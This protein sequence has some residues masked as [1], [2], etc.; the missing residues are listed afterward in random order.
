M[1]QRFQK[2]FKQH[3]SSQSFSLQKTMV[4]IIFFGGSLALAPFFWPAAIPTILLI[5]L[6]L[7]YF[8]L[9]LM[10]LIHYLVHLP[11]GFLIGEKTVSKHEFR[12]LFNIPMEII[13]M[14]FMDQKSPD[15]KQSNPLQNNGSEENYV[16]ETD[17]TESYVDETDPTESYVDETDLQEDPTAISYEDDLIDGTN[18]STEGNDDQHH[19]QSPSHASDNTARNWSYQYVDRPHTEAISE[20][21]VEESD[22]MNANLMNDPAEKLEQTQDYTIPPVPNQEEEQ[23]ENHDPQQLGEAYLENGVLSEQSITEQI[24]SDLATEPQKTNKE[25]NNLDVK[26]ESESTKSNTKKTNNKKTNTKKTNTKKTNTKKTK[27][28]ENEK[29]KKHNPNMRYNEEGYTEILTG[30]NKWELEHVMIAESIIDRKLKA[31]EVIHHI[32]LRKKDNRLKNI[33]VLRDTKD[34]EKLMRWQKQRRKRTG[35]MPT[36]DNKVKYIESMQG[37]V[38]ERRRY[39]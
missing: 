12:H 26:I 30:P 34:L 7:I 20:N 23:R 16:D 29:E 31:R 33:A 14:L 1:R 5:T 25:T 3:L 39:G 38:L 15:E 10:A 11:L 8:V 21:L 4:T 17:P 27:S 28:N 6:G 37:I 36:W 24:L 13:I 32:N 35:K 9:A 19:Y 2:M 18:D 22:T